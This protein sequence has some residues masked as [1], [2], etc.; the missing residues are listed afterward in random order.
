[1]EE[2]V[3]NKPLPESLS[4]L[5]E[6]LEQYASGSG[7]ITPRPRG[8]RLHPETISVL[9]TALATAE[10]IGKVSKRPEELMVFGNGCYAAGRYEDAAN[11]F[12][13][14]LHSEPSVSDARF[15]LGLTYLRLRR[16]E[17]A[18]REFTNLLV[19][20]PWLAEAF[21]QRG[22]GND[23]IGN[24]EQ[25]LADYTR[26]IELAPTYVHAMYNR[27]ILLAQ[28]GRHQEAVS[29]F[30]KVIPYRTGD[31]KLL[32]EQRGFVGRTGTARRGN[33]FLYTGNGS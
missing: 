11:A 23:D 12:L 24:I 13:T 19:Q 27:G 4:V 8:T 18:V 2:H 17:D 10:V 16:P 5:A 28:G 29:Q 15:N 20:Q 6:L 32:F 21:Y 31:I 33:Q 22:N 30:D 3:Q 14:I 26:A 1:M 25:A 7:R 9:E